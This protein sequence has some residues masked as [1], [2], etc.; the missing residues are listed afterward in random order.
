MKNGTLTIVPTHSDPNVEGF[1]E[2]GKVTLVADASTPD[3]IVPVFLHE[4]GGHVGMQGVLKPKAYENLM[5]EFNRLV[6]TGNPEAIE[7]KRLADRESDASVRADEYLPYLITVAARNQQ[8][9]NPAVRLVN[10]IL[11]AVKA[12]AVGVS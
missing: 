4:L 5:L 7:A 2:G 3:N 9:T 12:W 11:S 10:R 8:N 1:A 6:K